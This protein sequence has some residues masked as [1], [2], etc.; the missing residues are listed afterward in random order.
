MNPDHARCVCWVLRNVTDPEATDSA[1]RL[2]GTTWWFDDN[3][4]VDPPFD[5]I[6]SAFG[7]C[8]DL[9]QRLRPSMKDRAYLS[10]RAVPQIITCASCDP[11]SV[12]PGILTSDVPVNYMTSIDDDLKV[13]T[14]VPEDRASLGDNNGVAFLTLD[15]TGLLWMSNL[16]MH[17]AQAYQTSFPT[18]FGPRYI[19]HIIHNRVVNATL[20]AWYVFLGGHDEGTLWVVDES[21]VS[22][23]PT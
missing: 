19:A 23:Q 5:V 2:V 18:I 17:L 21:C 10:G 22:F 14:I 6:V 11:T 4:D 20:L 1:I 16:F 9:N 12:L 13:V 8:F 7:A 3:I 15:D